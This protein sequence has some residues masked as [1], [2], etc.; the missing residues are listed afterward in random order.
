MN[1]ACQHVLVIF[2][3]TCVG[4]AGTHYH[5]AI[6]PRGLD[7]GASICTMHFVTACLP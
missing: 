7:L 4:F 1:L 5:T 2:Q 6:L 3:T